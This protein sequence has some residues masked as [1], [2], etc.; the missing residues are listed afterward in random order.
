MLKNTIKSTDLTVDLLT[1]RLESHELE[2][3]KTNKVN[4]SSYQQN[5]ELDYRGS[6]IPK[7]VSPK[8][9]FSVE[10]SNTSNQEIS[11]S[12]YHGGSS[13]T[14]PSQ[15]V[16]KNL[17]QCNIAVD[18]KNA[19]NFSEESAKQQMVF[20]ASVL[21]SYESLVAGKIGNTNLTKEDYDQIDPEE[22]ELIDIRWCMASAVKRA[23]R[24]MEI[25]GRHS[26][27]GPSTKLGF[28]KSKVT[29]FKCKQK[30]HFKRECLNASADDTANPFREDYYKR[31]IY[32]QNKLESPR[33]KQL[34]DAP[35]E[36]SR[37]L[38]VIH[39]D[40]G[41]DWSELQPEEDAVG[42]AFMTKI[43]PFKDIRTEEVKYINRKVSAQFMKNRIYQTLKEA[44]RANRWDADRECYLDPKA[45]IVV[46]PDSVSVETH[47]EQIAE[48]EEARHRMWWRGGEADEKEKEK[49]LQPKK[50]DDRIIDTSQEFTAENLK[51]MADKVLAAKELEVVS[52]SGTESKSKVS[53]NDSTNES[54]KKAKTESDCKNCMKDYKVCST[55][56]YLSGK[57]T[58]ELT[59]RVRDVENQIL[60]RDKM[61]KASNERIKEL[62]GKIENDK[63]DVERTRKEN[64]KLV[65]ENR[66]LSENHEKLKRT[67]KDFDERDAK[68]SKENLQLSG[69][70]R[71]KEEQINQQL[72]EIANLKL[73][74]QE[75][76]IENER[77]NLKLN[78]Y[79]SASFVL[80]HI[81][82]KPIGKNKAGEDVYSD[83]TWVGYHQVPPPVLNNFSKKKI[84][85]G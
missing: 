7:T 36:K 17:F 6:M 5:V 81:V 57:K 65:H 11:S 15:S 48:E 39:D 14:A 24:F 16:P 64:E 59:E 51:K 77:I 45:N 73:Q 66:Q 38:A 62:T 67:I 74:F 55:L 43:V 13:S 18:L 8:T 29:C 41:F 40:E 49:E 79:N 63:I 2:I 44:K 30:G 76:K 60:S 21:E 37:A 28:D 3:R 83:G 75:A 19:Q 46:D 1:E 84:R 34:E 23:Q 22:M 33:M 70:L 52:E 47:T 56:A 26:I 25:T 80:Q 53:S 50:V 31:A 68:T 78:S 4:N 61:L 85:V 71:S 9:A 82:P 69:V 54:G 20:L 27:G 32:R 42:Y 10:N 72:D 58:E 35:K 12:G